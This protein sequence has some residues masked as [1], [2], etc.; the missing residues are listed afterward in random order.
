[1]PVEALGRWKVIGGERRGCGF[2]G[3][4]RVGLPAH[5]SDLPVRADHFDHGET[6]RAQVCCDPGTV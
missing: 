6:D 1:M 4:D 5:S 3:I 2:V